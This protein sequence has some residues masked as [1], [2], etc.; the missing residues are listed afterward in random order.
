MHMLDALRTCDMLMS[1]YMLKL[2]LEIMQVDSGQCICSAVAARRQSDS[3]H[4]SRI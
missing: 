3:G 1:C 4:C 2:T